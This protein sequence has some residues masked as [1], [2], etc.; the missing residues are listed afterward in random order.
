MLPALSCGGGSG[1]GDGGAAGEPRATLP[2]SVCDALDRLDGVERPLQT[3]DVFALDE[4]ALREALASR[5][6]VLD[7]PVAGTDGE[8]RRRLE[9]LRLSQPAFDEA[10]LDG[11]EPD[12]AR[13]ANAHDDAWMDDLVGAAVTRE[14]GEQIRT[15]DHAFHRNVA[16][17][18]LVIGCR[19]PE[20]AGGPARETTEDPPD[21]RLVFVRPDDPRDIEAGVRL[22]VTDSTAG[23]ERVLPPPTPWEALGWL[24]VEPGA[25]HGLLLAARQG[26]DFGTLVLSATGEVLDTVQRAPGQLMCP[27]WN[28]GSDQVLGLDNTSDADQRRV[29]LIDLTGARPSAPLDLPFATVGCADFVDADRLVVSEAAPSHDEDRGVWT[30]G[31]DGSDPRELHT[32]EG[33]TT[34]VGAVDPAGTRVALA[35]ACLDPLDDG[36]WVLDL[37]TGDADQVVTGHAATPKWSPDGEWLVFGFSPLGERTVLGIWQARADGRQLR[38]LVDP[39]VYGPVWLPAA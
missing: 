11:W 13:L 34:Q 21:G 24:D 38:R 32:P 16:Y 19:A 4:P 14:D 25:D 15:A 23:G 17:E 9:D 18:R 26:S 30:V 2:A 12:R 8:L 37:T 31:V 3:D 5:L 28:V 22:V 10:M 20:L 35:Q 39:L 1:G 36:V 6:A 33:C 29:H 7:E 27:A